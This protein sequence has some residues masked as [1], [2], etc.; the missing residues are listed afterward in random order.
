MHITQWGEYGVHFSVY[1][2]RRALDGTPMVS[3][4]EIAEAQQIDLQYA[5]QILQR[6]RKGEIVESVRGPQGGY[7]LASPPEQITLLD[8]LMATEGETFELL[9]DAK[10]LDGANCS[11]ETSCGLRRIWSDLRTHVDDFLKSY[12]L[13]ALAER[14]TGV[15]GIG[16]SKGS[17]SLVN[18]G[19]RARPAAKP[20]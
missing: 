2:A 6:L 15:K 1:L 17:G 4:A 12:T 16:T 8:I 14:P 7:R 18:I 19:V 11:S 13:A 9:C 3:A 10:P 5:Q 20:S